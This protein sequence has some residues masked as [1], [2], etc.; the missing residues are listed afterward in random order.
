[1]IR[2]M[3]KGRIEFGKKF[4]GVIDISPGSALGFRNI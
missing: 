3:V 2:G 4:R 1:M